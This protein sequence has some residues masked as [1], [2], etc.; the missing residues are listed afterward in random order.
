MTH[1]IYDENNKFIFEGNP[2]Q[3][4]EFIL[5]MQST[6]SEDYKIKYENYL[7]N[8]KSSKLQ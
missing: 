4:F 5:K 3:C 6:T 7:K 1:K 2:E 8:K